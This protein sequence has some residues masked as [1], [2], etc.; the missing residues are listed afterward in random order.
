MGTSSECIDCDHYLLQFAAIAITIDWILMQFGLIGYCLILYREAKE[1]EKVS[2]V[3]LLN[4]KPKPSFCQDWL[5]RGF[6]L[7]VKE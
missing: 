5:V 4:M 7:S 1:A 3:L 2:F 6:D